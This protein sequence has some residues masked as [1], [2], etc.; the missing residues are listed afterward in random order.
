MET[1]SF[2]ARIEVLDHMSHM[3]AIILPPGII[4]HI[5]R[6][7]NL[8]LLVTL[9]DTLQFQGGVVSLGN[10]QG[11]ISLT[12]NRMKTLGL[13][14]GMVVSVRLEPDQST[15]GLPICEEMQTILDLDEEGSRRFHQLTAGKQRT[16][17]HY[18][19]L[20]KSSQLRIDRALLYLEN[21]KRLPEGKEPLSAIFGK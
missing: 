4:Q 18:V 7:F 3:H 16:I 6:N 19:G 13:H 9:Q 15:Y 11:Y 1:V 10:G 21:L 12:K 5:G 2:S 8:R 14:L 20:V 17:I